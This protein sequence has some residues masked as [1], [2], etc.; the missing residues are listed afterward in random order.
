MTRAA[1][2]PGRPSAPSLALLLAGLASLLLAVPARAA[3]TPGSVATGDV[4]VTIQAPFNLPVTDADLVRELDA[5]QAAGLR[6]V[7]FMLSW[8]GIEPTRPDDWEPVALRRLERVV[9]LARARGMEVLAV[10][11]PAPVWARGLVSLIGTPPSDP[12][13]LGRF[14][15][16]IA[17]HFGD[18]ISSYQVWNEPNLL[19]FW[20]GLPDPERYTALLRA[21]YRGIKRGNPRATVLAAPLSPEGDGALSMS[22]TT[23][24]KR[25]YAAGAKGSF[26][27]IGAHPYTWGKPEAW[28]EDVDGIRREMVARGDG[29]KRIWITELGA[30]TARLPPGIPEPAQR[31]YV[32]EALEQARSRPFVG[33]VV[34]YCLRDNGTDRND[35][36][37]NFGLLRRDFSPKPVYDGVATLLRG[38]AREAGGTG[39]AS[40]RPTRRT[41]TAA[42]SAAWRRDAARRR[43]AARR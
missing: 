2:T 20:G 31:R 7:R 33:P 37:Q 4:G 30:S 18:R 8:A 17:R 13:Q 42:A 39:A 32:L 35:R 38:I 41:S 28:T 36:E 5:A 43:A 27:A 25:M 16:R 15:E 34:L 12:A 26:D 29:D 3:P 6:R 21:T 11:G 1:R 23:Y 19:L 22:P 9:A 14:G 24:V 40:V 10:L